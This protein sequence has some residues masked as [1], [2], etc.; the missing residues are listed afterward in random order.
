MVR[1]R[2]L[3]S[4]PPLFAPGQTCRS[5]LLADRLSDQLPG[6][7]NSLDPRYRFVLQAVYDYFREH[8]SWPLVRKLELDLE[9][10]VDPLGGLQ[11]VCISIGSQKMICGSSYNESDVCRLRLPGFLD[12]DDTNEDID[13]LLQVIRYCADKYRQLEGARLTVST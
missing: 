2:A 5:H 8:A 10:H 7:S 12:C 13:R 9:D 4:E 1:Y 6:M 11:F 3:T